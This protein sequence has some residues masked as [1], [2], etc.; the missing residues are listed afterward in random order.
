[1]ALTVQNFE[2]KVTQKILDK[3]HK[4]FRGGRVIITQ[5]SSTG[6]WEAQVEGSEEEYEVSAR[7]AP[8]GTVLSIFAT[9]PTTMAK[10][11]SIK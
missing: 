3:G 7:F 4:Y 6:V 8:D 2:E 11:V 9:A 1:M 10:S 5:Q